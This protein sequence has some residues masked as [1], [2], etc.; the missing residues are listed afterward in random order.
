MNFVIMGIDRI[1]KNTFIRRIL[2]GYNEIHLSKPPKDVDPLTWS[3]SQY[4]DYF[5]TLAYQDRVVFNRGHWDELVYVPRYRDYSAD[6]V[7]IMEDEYRDELKNTI[8][9]LLYTTDF[10]ITKDDGKSHD[11]TRRQEEQE[12][13]IEV[14]EKSKLKKLM[15]QVNEGKKYAGTNIVRQRFIEGLIKI[16]G[17]TYETIS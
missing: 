15:V 3:K 8:F 17:E 10:D 6:Y 11:F 2:N 13:F 9:I 5:M 14:F 16:M 1:G 12:A 4:L 7:R